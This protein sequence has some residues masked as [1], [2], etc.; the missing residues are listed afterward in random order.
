MIDDQ[1]YIVTVSNNSININN[2][3]SL[4][5][6][7]GGL[8][9]TNSLVAQL[10]PTLSHINTFRGCIR[11]V[12]SNGFYLD[13]DNPLLSANSISGPCNCSVTNSCT[14]RSSAATG[15]IVPWSVW[16]VVALVQLLLGT[17]LTLIFLTFLRR[18]QQQKTL[19][20]ELALGSIENEQDDDR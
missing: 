9:L 14:T 1:Q 17:I 16:L 12:K 20:D 10:Y 7:L 5:L 19:A 6:F 15:T 18:R 3:S 8:P 4:R 13:M 2:Q 11:N